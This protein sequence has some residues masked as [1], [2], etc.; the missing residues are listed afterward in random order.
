MDAVHLHLMLNHVPLLGTVFG[1]LV[2]LYGMMR[3]QDEVIKTSLGVFVVA[4]L[5]A[6]AVF[7]TGESAE[8]AIE[9]LAGVSEALIEPHE[10]TAAVA[11][12]MVGALGVLALAALFLLKRKLRGLAVGAVL[13]MAVAASGAMGWTAY[14]GGQI[15]HPEIRAD[16]SRPAPA[17]PLR[18]DDD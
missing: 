10:E 1:L 5:A 3:R 8:E 13:L 7:L 17:A 18:Y 12:W 16:A 4:A 9:G 14:L 15:S 6:G 2:L 11:L